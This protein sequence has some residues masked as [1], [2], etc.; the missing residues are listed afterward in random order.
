MR[1]VAKNFSLGYFSKDF[2]QNRRKI[3]IRTTLST[4]PIL[5]KN[6][7]HKIGHFGV[8][9]TRFSKIQPAIVLILAKN[10]RICTKKRSQV[11]EFHANDASSEC[12]LTQFRQRIRHVEIVAVKIGKLHG[13]VSRHFRVRNEL[14]PSVNG[15]RKIM[16]RGNRLQKIE[17]TNDETRQ[18]RRHRMH[19][20][21]FH[22]G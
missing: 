17:I 11:L 9:R 7:H 13:T 6:K 8:S 16:L 2:P 18:I 3:V 1:K 15:D 5:C 20:G 21:E 22:G 14:F 4:H 10:M 12:G 19:R